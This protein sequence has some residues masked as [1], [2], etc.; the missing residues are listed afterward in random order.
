VKR[1]NYN[2]VFHATVKIWYSNKKLKE[3]TAM[4]KISAK[5][6]HPETKTDEIM[7]RRKEERKT[8]CRFDLWSE[9]SLNAVSFFRQQMMR[10]R[11]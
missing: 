7:T 1:L 6:K 10:C 5:E 3:L 11:Q 2:F 9:E 8:T 4:Q